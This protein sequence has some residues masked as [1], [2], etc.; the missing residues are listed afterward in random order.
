[1]ICIP[2]SFVAE[3]ADKA[4]EALVGEDVVKKGMVRTIPQLGKQIV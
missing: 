2:R 3:D 1:M 4:L